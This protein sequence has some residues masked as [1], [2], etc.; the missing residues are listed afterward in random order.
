MSTD[1]QLP[2]RPERRRF[3]A[4]ERVRILADYEACTSAM[5]RAELIRR[6]GIY[7]S[8]ISNWRKQLRESKQTPAKR[9]RPANPEAVELRR[10]REENARLQRRLAK[11]ERTVSALGKAHALLQ[12]IA[13]ESATDETSSS[14]S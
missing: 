1:L 10:L 12:M 9:G 7:S 8:L 14:T 11:S 4:D 13:S 6:T 5:Q 3:S 2:S